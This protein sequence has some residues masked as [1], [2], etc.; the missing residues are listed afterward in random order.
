MALTPDNPGSTWLTFTVKPD[1]MDAFK[2]MGL[3]ITIPIKIPAI[4]VLPGITIPA[5]PPLGTPDVDAGVSVTFVCPG[6]PLCGRAQGA[7]AYTAKKGLH[8]DP[9]K[10][11]PGHPAIPVFDPVIFKGYKHNLKVPP[12][13]YNPLKCPNYPGK[14]NFFTG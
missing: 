5:M 14:V 10:L 6:Y 1:S 12:D 13:V 2:L 9:A 7:C 8:L 11:I 4:T 3:P